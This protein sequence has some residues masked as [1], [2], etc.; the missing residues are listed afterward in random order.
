VVSAI[1]FLNTFIQENPL[2]V[3][4]D[5]ISKIKKEL[6]KEGDDFKVKQKTGVIAYKIACNNRRKSSLQECIFDNMALYRI[7]INALFQTVYFG[8]FA[9]W[10]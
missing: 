5:E 4:A 10:D 2:L 6:V 9:H 3:C 8:D 1:K 7:N